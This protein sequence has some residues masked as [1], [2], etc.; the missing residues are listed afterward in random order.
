[1]RHNSHL[2]QVTPIMSETAWLY[3]Q[4]TAPSLQALHDATHM[5]V[6]THIPP[7][8][9]SCATGA[10]AVPAEVG[11]SPKRHFRH[12]TQYSVK[13]HPL[14]LSTEIRVCNAML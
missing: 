6:K 7:K 4:P 12:D 13:P 5:A 2:R 10:A 1:M 9:T 3:L 8:G 11:D 14:R